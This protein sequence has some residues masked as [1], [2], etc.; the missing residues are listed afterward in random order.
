MTIL[1]TGSAG[2]LGEALMRVLREAGRDARGIDI[3]PS[4]FTDIVGTIADRAFVCRALKGVSAVIH[5]ATLHKPHVATHGYTEFVETNIA[6]TLTLLEAA[7]SAG[8][9]AFVFTSTT[10]AFGSALTPSP[11]APAAWITEDVAPI[12]RNIYG[13][14]KVAAEG[15]CEL[16]ARRHGLPVVILRTSRFF[17]EADDDAGIRNRYDTANAQAN[18]L[19][20]RRADIEDVVS[21]HLLAIDKAKEI[22]FGRY[23]VSSPP[24]FSRDD[25]AELRSDAPSVVRRYFPECEALYAARGWRLF[26]TI[27]RVYVSTRA[28]E[29][30]GWKPK[31][32]FRHV[33]SCLR[34]DEDFRSLLAREIGS[35]GYHDTVFAEGPY[36]TA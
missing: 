20:Y 30:L 7:A 25:L 31:Y 34:R 1:V 23:I 32:D 2:H 16:F 27:D 15:F 24:P 22:R 11:G 3:K 18:E 17:P 33:L 26:L 6:G 29:A 21:A 36:P 9:G 35:K 4:A 8:V 14:S 12:P 19:L 10:S 5:A 13:V 28:M